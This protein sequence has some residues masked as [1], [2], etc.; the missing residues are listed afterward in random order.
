MPPD[1]LKIPQG[2]TSLPAKMEHAVASPTMQDSRTLLDRMT[3][4]VAEVKDLVCMNDMLRCRLYESQTTAE[5]LE[6]VNAGMRNAKAMQQARFDALDQEHAKLQEQSVMAM[7]ERSLEAARQEG[8]IRTCEWECER[9]RLE[10]ASLKSTS[11][12]DAAER[13]AQQ[14]RIGALERENKAILEQSTRQVEEMKS[15]AGANKALSEENR[16]LAAQNTLLQTEKISFQ[17]FALW[18]ELDVAKEKVAE[19][20]KRGLLVQVELD[21]AARLQDAHHASKRRIK[22]LESAMTGLRKLLSTQTETHELALSAAKAQLDRVEACQ[23]DFKRAAASEC[24]RF[25]G[26]RLQYFAAHTEQALD[27]AHVQSD[28]YIVAHELAEMRSEHEVARAQMATQR[29][30]LVSLTG[31]CEA[32]KKAFAAEQEQCRQKNTAVGVVIHAKNKLAA[33]VF[34]CKKILDGQRRDHASLQEY[35]RELE[36]EQRSPQAHATTISPRQAELERDLQQAHERLKATQA[37]CAGQLGKL[38]KQAAMR[39]LGFTKL[40]RERDGVAAECESLRAM[41]RPRRAYIGTDDVEDDTPEEAV[42]ASICKLYRLSKAVEVM[43]RGRAIPRGFDKVVK[44]DASS[45]PEEEEEQ[46][47]GVEEGD[48]GAGAGEDLRDVPWVLSRH[49]CEPGALVGGERGGGCAAAAVACGQPLQVEVSSAGSRP[50]DEDVP[51]PMTKAAAPPPPPLSLAIPPEARRE[52]ECLSQ[53]EGPLATPTSPKASPCDCGSPTPTPPST[54]AA[55]ITLTPTS[56]AAPVPR[57]ELL[58][59]KLARAQEAGGR[60]TGQPPQPQPRPRHSSDAASSWPPPPS[61]QDRWGSASAGAHP[62]RP[63]REE[64]WEEA[65]DPLPHAPKRPRV[66]RR[67]SYEETGAG[68]Y[69]RGCGFEAFLPACR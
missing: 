1:N 67:P 7:E 53:A 56:G 63:R 29:Q 55:A 14:S 9:L 58:P 17:K 40:K 6:K 52:I 33:E 37:E 16:R 24:A 54:A 22:E 59:N 50:M 34:E 66:F 43:V 64:E 49:Y 32:Y 47:G 19:M 30:Q 65:G 35:C 60:P 69:Y 42:R 46:L 31:V 13:S 21:E 25:A 23:A 41:K 61:P 20:E 28:H 38:A 5:K 36:V 48:V 12:E 3:Q 26:E 15:V 62:K 68:R 10:N 27:L 8:C 39:E 4:Q 45:M 44:D 57:R 2:Q 18:E 11:T 51:A